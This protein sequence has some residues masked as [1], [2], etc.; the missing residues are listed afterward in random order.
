MQNLFLSSSTPP[1]KLFSFIEFKKLQNGIIKDFILHLLQAYPDG[2]TCRQISE[3]SQIE[4]QSL[5]YPL[6]DLQDANLIHVTGIRKSDVS[7]R[8][9]QVY[10][11]LKVT[12]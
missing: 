8:M 4:V 5:T 7:N 3:I 11:V 12:E 9:V 10:S 6:K 1:T 2:L